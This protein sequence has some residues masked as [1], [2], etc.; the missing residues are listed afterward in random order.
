[1]EALAAYEATTTELTSS[2]LLNTAKVLD[3]I[4]PRPSSHRSPDRSIQFSPSQKR[5]ELARGL[6]DRP[7]LLLLLV[8]LAS[9]CYDLL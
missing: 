9:S 1:M 2:L 7:W 3:M 5:E 4:K 6:V 8:G